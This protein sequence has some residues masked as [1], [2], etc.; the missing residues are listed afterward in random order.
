MPRSIPMQAGS[1]NQN[2]TQL[3][4]Q[5]MPSPSNRTLMRVARS[6]TISSRVFIAGPETVRSS[7][8]ILGPATLA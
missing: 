5:C 8:S 4:A 2:H 3:T 6:L 7:T 1:Q